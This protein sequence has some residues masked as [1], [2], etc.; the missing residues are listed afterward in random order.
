MKTLI[1]N[2]ILLCFVLSSASAQSDSASVTT[3]FP[4][5]F[6]GGGI[7][8]PVLPAN[9]KDDYG[10][11]VNITGGYGYSLVPGSFGY[12]SI[13]ARISYNRY[14]VKSGGGTSR[15]E[16]AKKKVSLSGNASTSIDFSLNVKGTF[17]TSRTSI[18]P[19][20]LLGIGY[21]SSRGSDITVSGDTSFVIPED[22]ANSVLW[23]AGAGIDVP[24]NE[25]F[26]V[27]A[28]GIYF[29]QT[30]EEPPG[31]QHVPLSAGIR[32]RF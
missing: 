6:I 1:S 30:A 26:A 28:E 4:E 2:L 25:R 14:S 22:H 21:G 13:L 5:A 15:S 29:L 7:A 20:I 23:L 8:Y 3:K 31:W 32:Y 10:K 18:A 24:V 16:L 12:G 11:G 17:A 9:F 27:F 19:Y